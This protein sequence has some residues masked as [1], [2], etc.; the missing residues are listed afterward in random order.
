MEILKKERGNPWWKRLSA[1]EMERDYAV[2][3]KSKDS[4]RSIISRDLLEKFPEMQ[5]ITN[6]VEANIGGE[7]VKYLNVRRIK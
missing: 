7:K 2:E 1:F 3:E 4:V 5:L 6:E